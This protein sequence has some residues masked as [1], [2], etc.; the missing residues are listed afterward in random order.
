MAS[1][2]EIELMRRAGYPAW[3]I[4]AEI[5]GL[6]LKRCRWS[7]FAYKEVA[8]HFTLRGYVYHLCEDGTIYLQVTCVIPNEI[9]RLVEG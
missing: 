9:Y 5:K 6:K 2:R 3:L 1:E 8:D 7:E 4:D